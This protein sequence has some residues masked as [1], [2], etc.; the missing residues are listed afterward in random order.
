[1][2]SRLALVV[3]TIVLAGACIDPAAA[4]GNLPSGFTDESIVTRFQHYDIYPV[5]MSF[6]PDGSGRYLLADL[7][8]KIWIGDLTEDNELTVYMDLPDTFFKDEV[9]HRMHQIL[10]PPS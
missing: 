2:R 10:M 3:A 7:R 6:L 8:G 1:M 9:G 4:L 5:G